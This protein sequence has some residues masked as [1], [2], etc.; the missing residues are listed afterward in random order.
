MLEVKDKVL[1]ARSANGV[2]N[3]CE[4]TDMDLTLGYSL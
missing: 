4:W 2:I 3:R 1:F